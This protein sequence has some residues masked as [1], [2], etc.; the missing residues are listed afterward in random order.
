MGAEY[1][2]VFAQNGHLRDGRTLA[3]VDRLVTV[4]AN[5]IQVDEPD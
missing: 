1:R 5:F 2:E 4:V 3:C